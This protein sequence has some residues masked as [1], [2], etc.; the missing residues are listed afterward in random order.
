MI[1][2]E[3]KHGKKTVVYLLKSLLDIR[4]IAVENSHY[5]NQN[6]PLE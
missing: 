1:N 6:S 2:G 4:Q 3:L 5:P